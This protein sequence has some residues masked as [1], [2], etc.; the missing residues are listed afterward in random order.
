MANTEDLAGKQIDHYQ[1]LGLLG[2]GGMARVYEAVDIRLDRQVAIKIIRRS[3]FPPEMLDTILVRFQREARS[4]ARLS[5]ANIVRV[6]DYGDYDSA[7]YLVLEYLP[8]GNLADRLQGKPMAWQDAVAF[9]LPIARALQFAHNKDI[10]HRDIKPSNILFTESG[11]PMLSD[12]GIAK[13]LQYD[14]SGTLTGTGVGMGTPGYM[15]PEQWTGGSGPASDQYALGIVLYEMITGRRPYI[16]DTPAGI[17]IKQASEPAPNLR[18][19]APDL[20][21]PVE[22]AVLKSMSKEPAER[23]VDMG[24]FVR[25]L[26]GL[27]GA[28]MPGGQPK[29]ED[30]TTQESPPKEQTFPVYS[31]PGA[32]KTPGSPSPVTAS[33]PPRK[34]VV[35]PIIGAI[36]V[37]V[38][39]CLAGLPLLRRILTS[40]PQ[41]TATLQTNLASGST[42][43]AALKPTSTEPSPSLTATILATPSPSPSPI[44][45]QITDGEGLAMRLVP[46]G[47]FT[48][49]GDADAALAE[50]QKYRSDCQRDFFTDEEPQHQVYL[51]AFYVD[52]YEVTNAA[53]K[54][55][56]NAGAC[57]PPR[58]IGSYARTSYYGN[59]Q[60]DNYPVILVD[61]VQANAYCE[62]RG[63]SLPTEAQWEKAARGTDGRTYPWGEGID[64]TKAN[65]WAMEGGC[66]GDTS[67]AGSYESGKSPNG[68]YDLAG[69]VWE[70]VADW[71]ESDY[72][73]NSPSSNPLGPDSGDQRVLRGGAW[74]GYANNQVASFRNKKTP[75]QTGN[76]IGFRCVR[77][78]NP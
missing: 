27:A 48:M 69:N 49:G 61:W 16:A 59:S 20:P 73:A 5:H 45:E 11:E 35:I 78:A 39:A 36:A 68:I 71:Y 55:C 23:H 42:A 37:L 47:E 52:I 22:A 18:Q 57:S 67:E 46:A 4:L 33:G 21:A 66:V 54:L 28:S 65:Y 30:L 8:G 38:I 70:W 62:W 32:G 43:P 41:A 31:E 12:F 74:H 77:A 56:V 50:C 72:Y 53:Y 26:E 15:A 24:S 63:G 25:E 60:F 40:P 13:I 44:P 76:V 3:A 1:I 29:V 64:C 6:Y 7:P 9:I 51:D 2:Q 10:V 17:L 19:F 34:W 58:Q 14:E 75:D